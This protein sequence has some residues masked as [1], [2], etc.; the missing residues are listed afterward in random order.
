MK[1]NDLVRVYPHGEPKL[2]VPAKVVLLSE[3]GRSIA[4]ALGDSPPFLISGGGAAIHPEHGLMMLAGRTEL[5]GK[6]WGPWIET[7]GG[8]H[9]EIEDYEQNEVQ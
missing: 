5:D 3:N 4:L 8:G 7:F 1:V 2:A 9:Y 6:P